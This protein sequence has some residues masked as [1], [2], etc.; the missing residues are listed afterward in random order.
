M[1]YNGWTNRVTWLVNLNLTN[2]EK[3]YEAVVRC[4]TPS[5]I[6]RL[7]VELAPTMPDYPEID[8][9]LADVNWKEIFKSVRVAK[10]VGTKIHRALNKKV[11][12]GKLS[13]KKAK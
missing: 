13:R 9:N 7:V 2:E 5:E 6:L 3:L 8:K 4:R 10:T 11:S 1:K 12:H